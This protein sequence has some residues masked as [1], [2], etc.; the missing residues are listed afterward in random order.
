MPKKK[1]LIVA[2]AG[3]S[4]PFGMPKSSDIHTYFMDW[5][6]HDF[7]LCS[8]PQTNLYTYL[9]KVLNEHHQQKNI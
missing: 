2:G 1:L 6:Q 5:A 8:N 3:A 7:S 9:F 4:I